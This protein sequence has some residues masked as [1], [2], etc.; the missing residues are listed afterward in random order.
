MITPINP[1]TTIA[2]VIQ[3]GDKTQSQDQLITPV[4]F[5]AIKTM[6]RSPQKPIPPDEDDDVLLMIFA[7]C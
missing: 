6:V 1:N 5:R 2:P 4:N 7:F 3:I